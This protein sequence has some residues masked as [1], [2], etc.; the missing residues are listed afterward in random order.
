MINLPS[1]AGHK[2]MSCQSLLCF[3]KKPSLFFSKRKFVFYFSENFSILLCLLSFITNKS[4]HSILQCI[5]QNAAGFDVN[6]F[7]LKRCFRS[8][9]FKESKERAKTYRALFY[10]VRGT[11]FKRDSRRWQPMCC[12]SNMLRFSRYLY[13]V[14]DRDQHSNV[15]SSMMGPS[16]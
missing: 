7:F 6:F 13:Y 8:G 9:Y 12:L 10:F 4:Y 5:K 3:N 2:N 11:L 15:T 14:R 16:P 1:Y